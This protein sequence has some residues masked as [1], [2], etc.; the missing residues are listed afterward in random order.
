MSILQIRNIFKSYD[1]NLVLN[2]IS[3]DIPSQSI[4]GL[5]GPNGAGKTTLIRIVNQIILP[6]SGSVFFNGEQLTRRHISMMGYLPEERG[7]YAKMNVGEQ[8]MYL[9]QLKGFTGGNVRNDI[10]KILSEFEILNWW[11][12]KVETL[13]KGMQQKLQFIVAIMHKPSL[14]ILDE[15][16]SGFDPIN[17]EMVKNKILQMRS[18]GTSFILSTHRME[19]VEELCDYMTLINKS[20]KIIEGNITDV[21]NRFRKNIYEISYSGQL[22]PEHFNFNDTFT[23]IGMEQQ[24]A[25]NIS[26]IRIGLSEGV[27][28]NQILE[29]MMPSCEIKSLQEVIPSIHE[30]FISLVK[31]HNHE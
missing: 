24:E 29:L 8:M 17:V 27:K 15:P 9:A 5:L 18:E 25:S 20:E 13:S 22:N 1:K 4:Y 7:L 12:K 11:N 10:R 28:I 23:L 6:D 2:D 26:K 3:M 21:K 31:E 19:S 16:F 30:I 14:V